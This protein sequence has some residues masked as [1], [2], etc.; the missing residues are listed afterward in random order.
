MGGFRIPG[1]TFARDLPPAE[2]TYTVTE[3]D[4]FELIS[5]KT[6]GVGDSAALIKHANPGTVGGL[7]VGMVLTIPQTVP[8]PATEVAARSGEE[9]SITVGGNLF[10]FWSTFRLRTAIDG[11]AKFQFG[12]VHEPANAAFRE[13]FTPLRFQ[14]IELYVGG[15]RVFAGRMIG[16]NPATTKAGR[17]VTVE[18]YA[19]CGVLQDC[20][21]SAS[22]FASFEQ[23]DLVESG[24]VEWDHFTLPDIAKFQAAPFGLV[25]VFES[26]PELPI[27]EDGVQVEEFERV[28][29]PPTQKVWPFW[30]GLA[31]QRNLVIGSNADGNPA[32]RRTN[33]NAATQ[34]LREGSSPV[35]AIEPNFRPQQFYSSVTGLSPAFI[36]EEGAQHT[37]VNPHLQGIHRPLTFTVDDA[38]DAAA[39]KSVVESKIARMFADSL[40]YRVTMVGS[41][42]VHGELWEANTRV[43][44]LAPG[45]MIREE[46]EFL[47]RVVELE[48]DALKQMTVLTCVLPESFDGQ[49]PQVLPWN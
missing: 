4:D 12:A 31:K 29:T 33:P 25:P 3:E 7:R 46:T 42:D 11:I 45:A 15:K 44:L 26:A 18:G 13:I 2:D 37:I 39:A 9:V 20:T 16:V 23:G 8:P 40:S 30:V 49:V 22:V 6:F 10:R 47:I 19:R 5:K 27:D 24:G 28:A 43:R 38:L 14:P 35:T 17:V 1:L 48:G 41:R 32:F 21:M 36:G 34:L